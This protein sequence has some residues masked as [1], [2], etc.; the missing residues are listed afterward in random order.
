MIFIKW[1]S[2][3]IENVSMILCCGPAERRG[4]GH[5]RRRAARA[6]PAGDR[7]AARALREGAAGDGELAPPHRARDG[8]E[9]PRR[10]R[11]VEVLFLF[12]YI[13]RI[14]YTSF[15]Y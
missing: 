9:A 1:E 8:G 13:S 4:R 15:V 2:V 7:A 12:H 3:E 10:E 6:L 11:T 14:L 5:A